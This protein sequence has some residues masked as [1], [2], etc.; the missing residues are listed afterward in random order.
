MKKVF[1]SLETRPRL[2]TEIKNNSFQIKLNILKIIAFC[3]GDY[4]RDTETSKSVTAFAAN[5]RKC[6]LLNTKI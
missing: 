2:A 6:F 1:T 3:V 4:V 5:V